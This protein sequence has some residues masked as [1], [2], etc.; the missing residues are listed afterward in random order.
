MGSVVLAHELSSRGSWALEHRFSSCGAWLSCLV[1]RDLTRMEPMSP[2][3]ASRDTTTGLIR[4][5]QHALS[6]CTF[7]HDLWLELL[8]TLFHWQI[9]LPLA[10]NSCNPDIWITWSSSGG[11]PAVYFSHFI[12]FSLLFDNLSFLFMNQW[13]PLNVKLQESRNHVPG[14]YVIILQAPSIVLEE[15]EHSVNVG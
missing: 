10:E 6:F 9:W 12:T 5:S 13:P 15:C 11:H 7:T 2:A 1:A 4:K 14:W 3:L 8:Y